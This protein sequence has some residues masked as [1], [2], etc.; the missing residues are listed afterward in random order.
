MH[1]HFSL[2]PFTLLGSEYTN[3][4]NNMENEEIWSLWVLFL[5]HLSTF[6]DS[7][8]AQLFLQ[9]KWSD[10]HH[11]VALS[12]LKERSKVSGEVYVSPDFLNLLPYCF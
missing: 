1:N 6:P 12:S 2:M 3:H 10:F 7:I 11:Y 9:V 8:R 4:H 5:N